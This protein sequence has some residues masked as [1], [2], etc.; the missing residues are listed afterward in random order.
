M[1][2]PLCDNVDW[3]GYVDWNV[4]DFHGYVTDRGSTYNSYLVR[5]EKLAVIDT[6]KARHGAQFLAH[7]SELADPAKLDYVVVQHAEPDH[8]GSL[9]RLMKVCPQ[10][11]VVT[12]KRCQETLSSYYDTTGWTFRLVGSGDTLEL[13]R[14][15]LA[16]VE[17]PMVHWPDSMV[18]YMPQEKI[19]FSQDA[20]GQHYASTGRFD[21]EVSL[22]EAMAEAKT[23]YANIIMWAGKPIARALEAVRGLDIGLI[24]PA[25]GIMW[26]TCIGDIV[27]AYQ[28]WVRCCPRPKV[29]VIYDTMWESTAKMAEAIVEGAT[30]PGVEAKLFFV[31]ATNPTILAT[32][33]LDAAAVAFGSSTLNGTLLPAAAQVLAYYRGL[34]PTGKAGLAFGSYGWSR[35]GAKAVH[36][37]LAETK[38]EMLREPL[39]ALYAPT[40]EVLAEC[41]EAGR[42]LADRALEL[43]TCSQDPAAK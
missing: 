12:N 25:H 39:E 4:R 5:D 34:R 15:S 17:T 16:F 7:I 33:V 9:P 40:P 2:H 30:R 28:D 20:F 31:R 14:R 6:V 24:A 13:G 43:V 42:M 35:G 18:S 36:E 11:T 26:R 8:S 29:L 10:A 41:R 3:V 32:E 1:T 23:Y 21:D 38:F 19:L 37:A 22:E 27:G